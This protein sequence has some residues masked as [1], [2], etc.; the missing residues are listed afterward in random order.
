MTLAKE[1]FSSIEFKIMVSTQK[2]KAL[3]W[4][5]QQDGSDKAMSDQDDET[6]FCSKEELEMNIRFK[7]L[8]QRA[9]DKKP[10]SHL[11]MIPSRPAEIPQ[12]LIKVSWKW[13]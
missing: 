5:A 10:F 4:R 11:A 1:R 6:F 13:L 3:D 12:H 7:L 8:K 2:M 9:N